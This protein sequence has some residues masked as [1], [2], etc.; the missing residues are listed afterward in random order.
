MKILTL[1][2]FLP[3]ALNLSAKE[4]SIFQVKVKP[5]RNDYGTRA[6]TTFFINSGSVVVTS[7]VNNP[8]WIEINGD[9]FVG[10]SASCYSVNSGECNS[11]T[12]FYGSEGDRDAVIINPDA[13]MNATTI[14]NYSGEKHPFG[15]RG[16]NHYWEIEMQTN[17]Q[18]DITFQVRENDIPTGT[19]L[20]NLRIW[21]YY[22]SDW[23]EIPTSSP[24]D[25][26][27]D[28]GFISLSFSDVSFNSQTNNHSI[29]LNETGE[30]PTSIILSSFTAVYSGNK[31]NIYWI[32]QSEINNFG[33]N[34]HRS[35]TENMEESVL[36]NQNLISGAGS[37]TEPS[38]Y[39]FADEYEVS[40]GNSYY[41]WLESVNFSGIREYFGPISLT[42]PS[43]PNPDN[44]EITRFYGLYQNYPNPA[45]HST[46]IGFIMKDDCSA[47]LSVYNLKGQKIRTLF[48][49]RTIEKDKLN[50]MI[51]DG[52]D[53]SGNDVYSGIYFYK[54]TV[55][56]KI[57]M[58][59]MILMR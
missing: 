15:S 29:T 26:I 20:S 10:T 17:R 13:N 47:N 32:T 1:I 24:N 18:C 51:W 45:S 54:L 56:K 5:S 22:N 55:S 30:S 40:I 34:I 11:E 46:T 57:Y 16:I 33:W 49:K 42:I 52:K 39:L 37:S 44:N 7:N 38:E 53:E 28:T 59:K 19:I 21:E 31:P 2:L 23:T 6:G 48:S 58:K 12:T 36:I 35:E 27:P 9:L 25:R 41:Y 8:A 3:L 43:N 50:R 4:Y 14:R